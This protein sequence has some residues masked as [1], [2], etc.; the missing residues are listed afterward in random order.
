MCHPSSCCASFHEGGTPKFDFGGVSSFVFVADTD[1]VELEEPL[2]H[3]T[4]VGDVTVRVGGRFT[5]EGHDVTFGGVVAGE[6]DLP[7]PV[8]VAEHLD[9][10]LFGGLIVNVGCVGDNVDPVAA[11]PPVYMVVLEEEPLGSIRF[12]NPGSDRG[13]QLPGTLLPFFYDAEETLLVGVPVE[14]VGGVH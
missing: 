9:T 8:D 14:E 13:T 12:D 3:E 10:E 1:E 7:E 6:A 4:V 2:G 5:D 11:Y